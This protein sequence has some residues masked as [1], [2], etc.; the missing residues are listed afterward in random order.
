M[1]NEESRC[2]QNEESLL[3]EE[4]KMKDE[5]FAASNEN[6]SSS[7]DYHS[8]I[9]SEVEGSQDWLSEMFRLRFA[10]LNMTDY[11]LMK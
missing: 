7:R 1:K 6:S 3:N 8:V 10:T 9:P 4:R 5:E 2:A 11:T